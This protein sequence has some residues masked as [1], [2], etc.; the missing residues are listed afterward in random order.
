MRSID[1]S[2][3]FHKDIYI[4]IIPIQIKFRNE[5]FKN[6]AF[7]DSGATYSL[8][9]EGFA[10]DMGLD[11]SKSLQRYIV[12]GDGGYIPASFVKMP[13]K[14]EDVELLAE[15]GF[16]PKLGVGFNLLGRKDVFEKFRVCFS[17]AEKKINFYYE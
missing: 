10:L 3:S 11:L 15:I 9:N 6:W 16:S 2:Y 12:V 4:P 7:V 14:I 17:D 13:L 5:W 8:F 1:F